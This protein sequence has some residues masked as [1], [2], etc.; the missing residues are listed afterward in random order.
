MKYVILFYLVILLVFCFFT[1]APAQDTLWTRTYGG[2]ENDWGVNII[3]TDDNGFAILSFTNSF[4]NG[5]EDIWLIKTNEDGD[6]IWTKTYGG[7]GSES[8]V[9]F[10][11][12]S[13]GGFIIVGW[14][15]TYG[16]GD[17]DLW[18]I[19]TN[20]QGDT[21]WTKTYGGV[22]E[23]LGWDI[24][25]LDDGYIIGGGTKSFGSGDSD[26]WLL[27]TD[28][29]GDTLWTRTYGEYDE[30]CCNRIQLT[31]DGGYIL[32]GYK[33]FPNG[34]DAWLVKTDENGDPLWTRTYG[35]DDS[36]AATGIDVTED[37]GF[38]ICGG[39]E[40]YG[41]GERDLWLI[42]TDSEGNTIWSK[43]LGGSQ[44]DE[45][46]FAFQT[47]DGGYVASGQTYSFGAGESDIYL[48]RLDPNGDTLWTRTYGGND[49]EWGG[50]LVQC[51]DG[52]FLLVGFSGSFGS[53]TGDVWLLKIQWDLV[54]VNDGDWE[55]NSILDSHI[56]S[57]NYPNPFNSST[58]IYYNIAEPQ[59]V[60]LKIY[61]LQGQL[62]FDKD[63]DNGKLGR[64]SLTWDAHPQPSG[65][66]FY[67]LII[68]N[69]VS[70]R[71]ILLIK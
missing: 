14:T 3:H 56:H 38:I 1:D 46:Y 36:D 31:S 63:I 8:A 55:S 68:G 18:L 53:G 48:I 60:K 64:Q 40:S 12:T 15:S 26:F 5:D 10:R 33:R 21:V 22:E 49:E 34:L 47:S 67:K 7:I 45:G 57:Y 16:N 41:H 39:T 62:V 11:Q 32:A 50:N 19:K 51:D 69:D 59:N 35:G 66:Y 6:T 37:G 20:E 27:R 9:N 52:N 43:T 44:Q 2:G 25:V 13:D 65:I 58:N 71:K 17:L 30:E 61:N 28:L 54:G 70:T 24:R 42:K 23:D 29:N 4:G